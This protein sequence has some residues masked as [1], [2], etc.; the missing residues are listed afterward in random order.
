MDKRI[1]ILTDFSKEALNAARYALDLYADRKCTFY[2]LNTYYADGYSIDSHNYTDFGRRTFDNQEPKT[3]EQFKSLIEVLNLQSNDPIHTYN[4]IFANNALLEAVDD[5]VAKHDIDI[6]IMGAKGM[7]S[8]RP[9]AFGMN[10][11]N[12]ME[13]SKACPVLAIPEDVVFKTPRKIV[14]PTDYKT[15]FK[16]RELKYLINIAGTHGT[17]IQVIHIKESDKLT[18]EQQDNKKLLVTL[19]KD[20][21][22]SFHELNGMTV[23]EGIN[24]FIE[25]HESDMVAFIN[26]KSNFFSRLVS[27]PLVKDLGYQSHVPVLV[28]RHRV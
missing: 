3:E 7:T 22:H 6:I 28:L 12:V 19:F 18:K 9:V 15:P 16:R 10:T 24:A 5:V 2:F 1:L 4:T 20:V 26:Q 14:F 27:K 21:D 23:L 25:R 8:S 17:D 11:I 13:N